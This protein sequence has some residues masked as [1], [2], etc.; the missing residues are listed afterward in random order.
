MT[1]ARN[2]TSLMCELMQ[3]ARGNFARKQC[4]MALVAAACSDQQS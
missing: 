3:Q 1:S 4:A 2:Q